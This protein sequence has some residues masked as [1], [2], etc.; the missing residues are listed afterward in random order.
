MSIGEILLGLGFILI[1]LP[2]FAW[3]IFEWKRALIN[4]EVD[5]ILA[6]GGIAGCVLVAIGINSI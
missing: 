1:L 6:L 5:R 3:Y 2:F 4:W